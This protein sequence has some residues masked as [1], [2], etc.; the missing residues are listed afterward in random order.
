MMK[1]SLLTILMV[2]VLSSGVALAQTT[3]KA[4]TNV[5]VT[6]TPNIGVSFVTGNDMGTIG[7]IGTFSQPLVF[8]VDANKQ[9]VTLSVTVTE[10]Y[11]DN[12]PASPFQSIPIEV[13]PGVAVVPATA[14]RLPPGPNPPLAYAGV[15]RNTG[16]GF[17]G[18]DTESG[19]FGSGKST[20]S[21]NVVVTPTWK[22]KAETVVGT[23]GGQVTLY[24]M[25]AP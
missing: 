1:R 5:F 12:L 7:T 4:T 18:F 25:V 11:K 9:E 17:M 22:L 14:Q 19:K 21:E 16:N 23:Y 6:V 20:F 13:L 15:E 24:A 8:R 2:L 3:G 10:L